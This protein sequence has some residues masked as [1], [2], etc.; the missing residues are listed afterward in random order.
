[1]HPGKKEL[2]M[3]QRAYPERV[4]SE[5]P[6]GGELGKPGRIDWHLPWSDETSARLSAMRAPKSS[7]FSSSERHVTAYHGF[8]SYDAMQTNQSHQDKRN[9]N[10]TSRMANCAKTPARQPARRTSPPYPFQQ[11]NTSAES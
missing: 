11:K 3:K 10:G 1:M 4:L 7:S 8:D 5:T 6:N 2:R 9:S